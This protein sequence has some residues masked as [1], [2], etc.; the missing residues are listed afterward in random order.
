MIQGWHGDDYL[1]LFEER[2]DAIALTERYALAA[3][4]PGHILVG[5]KGWDDFLL[6][7]SEGHHF[8]VPTVPHDP[9]YLAPFDFHVN[10]D[11]VLPDERFTNKIKWYI[12]PIVFGGHPSDPSNMTWLTLD[13]HVE[14]VRFWNKVYRDHNKKS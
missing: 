11:A 6:R 10:V 5:L 1:M 14:A 12:K 3:S 4:L 2:D 13:Q 8:T 7:N 9:R